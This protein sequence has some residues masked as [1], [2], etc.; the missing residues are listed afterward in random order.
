MSIAL[1][2]YRSTVYSKRMRH[3][4]AIANSNPSCQRNDDRQLFLLHSKLSLQH[5]LIQTH[6][7]EMESQKPPILAMCTTRIDCESLIP[8]YFK[9]LHLRRWC[10]HAFCCN[11][12]DPSSATS[13]WEDCTV[14]V[15][16]RLL[17]LSPRGTT[18]S[19]SLSLQDGLCVWHPR[20]RPIPL[21]LREQHCEPTP[22]IDLVSNMAFRCTIL[23]CEHRCE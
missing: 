14:L 3:A 22:Y 5:L 1:L 9:Y 4:T 11:R 21:L 6:L 13:W 12:R 10:K 20:T 17:H 15:T 2:E 16:A 19:T 23:E 7:T 8:R 18:M